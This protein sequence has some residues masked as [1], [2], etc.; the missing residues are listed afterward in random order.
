MNRVKYLL[1]MYDL[2]ENERVMTEVDTKEKEAEVPNFLP[3]WLVEIEHYGL[4][5]HE[6]RDLAAFQR[7]TGVD[8]KA[9]TVESRSLWGGL[10]KTAFVDGLLEF[11][12]G[13]MMAK[14]T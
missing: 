8:F 10:D 4:G 3:S 13:N 6:G 5:N 12:M 2:D 7:F 14:N 1:G 11:V 9:G